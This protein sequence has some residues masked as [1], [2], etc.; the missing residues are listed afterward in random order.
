MLTRIGPPVAPGDVVDAL[1]DCHQRIRE[2]TAL[3]IRLAETRGL[4]DAEISDAAARVHRYFSLALPL[5]A[6]DEEESILPRLAGADPAVDAALAEMRREHAGHADAVARVLTACA[7]L[8]E[9]PGALP[10]IAADLAAAG[11]DLERHFDAHLAREEQ[12][13]FP[14]IRARLDRATQEQVQ[15]EMR[16]RRK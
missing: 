9:R 4:P 7:V 6:Q 2:F 5:H 10:G 14:A 16:A 12:T 8:R 1:V 3:A 15:A 11:H 13:I